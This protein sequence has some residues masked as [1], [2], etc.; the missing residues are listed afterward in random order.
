MPSALATKITKK[1]QNEQRIERDK[2]E[3][4]QRTLAG[5][6]RM[7]PLERDARIYPQ[8]YAPVMIQHEGKRVIVPMRYQCRLPGW[9]EFVERKF[10]PLKTRAG[11]TCKRPGPNCSAT[12]TGSW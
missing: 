10:P 12:A 1:A 8:Q 5:L 2:M 7:E 4:A 9:N 3:S 6:K 11:T